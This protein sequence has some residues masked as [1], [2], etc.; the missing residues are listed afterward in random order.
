MDHRVSAVRRAAVG[1]GLAAVGLGVVLGVAGCS[2]SGGPSPSGP[3][4]SGF[5]Q[6]AAQALVTQSDIERIAGPGFEAYRSD[7]V[8]GNADP[9]ECLELIR[10][11]DG[12]RTGPASTVSSAAESF[13]NGSTGASITNTAHVFGDA[14]AATTTFERLAAEVKRCGSFTI[15]VGDQLL[16]AGVTKVADGPGGDSSLMV[17]IT[18]TSPS[19]SSDATSVIART[20]RVIVVAV[21]GTPDG[22][23]ERAWATKTAVESVGRAAAI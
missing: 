23:D 12:T 20:G 3:S 22:E 11:S 17:R 4:A 19:T 5:A 14:A 6:P 18:V 13:A 1:V 8:V 9:Q 15:R 16:K 10:I 2:G 7:T 21:A